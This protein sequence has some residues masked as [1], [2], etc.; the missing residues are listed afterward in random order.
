MHKNALFLWRIFLYLG[1]LY[2][3]FP[4]PE[5]IK[6]KP[7]LSYYLK[8]KTCDQLGRYKIRTAKAY[9]NQLDCFS[10]IE[11]HTTNI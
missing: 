4:K 3:T 6:S 10:Y 9:I 1:W 7:M 8:A 5:K 11:D 2:P